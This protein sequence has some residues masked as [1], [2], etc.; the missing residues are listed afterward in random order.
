MDHTPAHCEDLRLVIEGDVHVPVL[1]TFVDRGKE[2]L[3]PILDPLHRPAQHSAASGNDNLFRI[4]QILGAETPAH[5]GRDDAQLFVVHVE[6][7]N[8][9]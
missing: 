9:R 8:Q 7:L 6:Q 3:A 2:V 5:I 4:H 1:V